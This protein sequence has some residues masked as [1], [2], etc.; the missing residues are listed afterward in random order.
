MAQI[1]QKYI[2]AIKKYEGGLTADLKDPASKN[3]SNCG[4]DKNGNPYHTNKGVTWASFQALAPKLGYT[5]D[6]NTFMTMPD[7]VWIKIFKNGY[8]DPVQLDSVNSNGLAYLLADFSWGS[9]PGYVKPFLNNFLKTNYNINATDTVSQ[10]KALNDLTA[11]NE[12]DV[13]DKIADARL[14]SLQSMKGG[15][16]FATYGKGWTTRLNGLKDL[17]HSVARVTLQ[18][19][20]GVNQELADKTIEE[21]KKKPWIIPVVAGVAILGTILLIKALK[22]TK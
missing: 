13:I 17:A 9:G 3:P 4:K 6:C 22:T 10:N 19:A 2:D 11:K 15:T 20:T 16:L 1:T 8:W 21:V 5:A 14:K 18:A 12:A 7:A